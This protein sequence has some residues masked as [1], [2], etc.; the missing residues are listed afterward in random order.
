MVL[1]IGIASRCFR[2]RS[3]RYS[4]LRFASHAFGRDDAA[5]LCFG[6]RTNTDC[7]GLTRTEVD[8]MDM[9]GLYGRDGR[10]V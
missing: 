5:L 4:T 7:H 2:N 3:L 1:L 9:D 10:G 6:T 8:V